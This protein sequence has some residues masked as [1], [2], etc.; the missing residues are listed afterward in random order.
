M[1][2][3]AEHDGAVRVALAGELDMA[4]VPRVDRVL[5]RA[6]HDAELVV[7]DLRELW[8]MDCSGA[9]LVVEADRRARLAGGRLLIVRGPAQVDWFFGLIGLDRRLELVDEPPAGL[10][11]PDVLRS[12]AA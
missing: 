5:R 11:G 3:Q 2:Y 10:A 12:V 4:S 1:R 7:L 6:Q 9:H 8:F